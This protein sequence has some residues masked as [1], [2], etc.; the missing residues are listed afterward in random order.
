[1]F[2][3]RYCGVGF[4]CVSVWLYVVMVDRE[5]VINWCIA[6]SDVLNADLCWELSGS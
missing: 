5:Y 6:L 3:V 1:M 4:V 2:H